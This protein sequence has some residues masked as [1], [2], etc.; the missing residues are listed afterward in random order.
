MSRAGRKAEKHPHKQQSVEQISQL[1]AAQLVAHVLD[2]APADAHEQPKPAPKA[3][4]G[5]SSS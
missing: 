3:P 5:G 4:S 2:G 1:V